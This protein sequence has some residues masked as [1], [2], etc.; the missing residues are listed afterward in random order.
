M[1]GSLLSHSH[2]VAPPEIQHEQD[3]GVPGTGF[4]GEET[5]IHHRSRCRWPA[6]APVD[7]VAES[8]VK[9]PRSPNH[10][11]RLRLS[12]S[13]RLRWRQWFRWYDVAYVVTV[14]TQLP[15]SCT[16]PLF[17]H[18]HFEPPRVVR[19]SPQRNCGDP[20]S[21]RQST[22]AECSFMDST[23]VAFTVPSVRPLDV[24]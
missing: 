1:I 4:K 12:R 6:S 5:C 15:T 21:P 11:L 22:T 2:H 9:M 18:G 10:R 14:R 19:L 8:I 20:W 16:S 3:E 7:S 23:A 13:Q 24:R 17:G